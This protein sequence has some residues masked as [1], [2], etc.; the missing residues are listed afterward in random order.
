MCGC[1]EVPSGTVMSTLWSSSSVFWSVYS[2]LT[3]VVPS[4]SSSGQQLMTSGTTE[5]SALVW[6]DHRRTPTARPT[7][8]PLS[9]SLSVS[10]LAFSHS[11]LSTL[12]W[13]WKVSPSGAEP[14]FFDAPLLPPMTTLV[15]AADSSF[16]V[17]ESV[18]L[19]SNDS[20]APSCESWHESFSSTRIVT[21]CAAA[22]AVA[23]AISAA[24]DFA[25]ESFLE[26]PSES[27]ARLRL[28][29]LAILSRSEAPL[30]LPPSFIDLTCT[31]ATIG[32][33]S[34]GSCCGS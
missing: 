31:G 25:F 10:V 26:P 21:G 19:R 18:P 2:M 29:S 8:K 16:A 30:G 14:P 28:S 12:G 20:S 3:L 1:A 34:T 7:G 33:G 22:G 17:T 9:L 32:S 13:T 23:S 6:S 4:P 15:L 11:A 27:A 5:S 24:A